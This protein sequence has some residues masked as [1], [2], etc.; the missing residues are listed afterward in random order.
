MVFAG[1]ADL[2]S[3]TV[4]FVVVD[5]DGLIIH[6]GEILDAQGE[7]AEFSEDV[8]LDGI[9]HVGAGSVIA[10]EWAP[11]GSQR[12]VVEYPLNLVDEG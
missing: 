10:W 8:S 12:H 1:V 4:S 5:A 3:G 9:P 2:E 7:T 11:D 6:E